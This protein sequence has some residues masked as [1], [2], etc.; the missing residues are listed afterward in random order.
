MN[1]NHGHIRSRPSHMFLRVQHKRPK[2]CWGPLGWIRQRLLCKGLLH[3]RHPSIHPSII[4]PSSIHRP[5]IHPLLPG[6]SSNL[7]SPCRATTMA[8]V[9][10]DGGLIPKCRARGREGRPPR[11]RRVVCKDKLK[12]RHCMSDKQ[13]SRQTPWPNVQIRHNLQL[14]NEIQ[15]IELA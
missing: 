13:A 2:D 7:S 12:P 8:P 1:H 5:S 6:I 14:P 11:K 9:F 4:H 15:L 3:T 10:R